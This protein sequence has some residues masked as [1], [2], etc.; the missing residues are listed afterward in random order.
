[1]L[2]S[3]AKSKRAAGKKKRGAQKNSKKWVGR[4]VV[5]WRVF[6]AVCVERSRW[7]MRDRYWTQGFYVPTYQVPQENYNEP[8]H[9]ILTSGH[10]N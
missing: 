1:M 8:L 7:V 9:Q 6:E 5:L 3:I 2:V 4:V 10:L